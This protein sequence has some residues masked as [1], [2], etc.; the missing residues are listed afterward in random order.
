MPEDIQTSGSFLDQL[1]GVTDPDQIQQQVGKLLTDDERDHFGEDAIGRVSYALAVLGVFAPDA[2]FDLPAFKFVADVSD[3][4]A[5]RV[6]DYAARVGIL[7]KQ[8]ERYL[9]PAKA[10]QLLANLLTEDDE[11]QS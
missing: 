1:A 8:A 3:D 4:D 7:S 9:L 10:Q 5:Q 6:L 11:K 2:T